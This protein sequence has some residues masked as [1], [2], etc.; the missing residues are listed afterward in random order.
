[1]TETN[2]GRASSALEFPVRIYYEDTDAGGIVYYANYLR[3][4]ERARTEWLRSRDIS[5][6]QLREAGQGLFVVRDLAIQYRQPAVLDD[7]LVVHTTI[8]IVR[9]ASLIFHQE[10]RRADE[11]LCDAVVTV[12]YVDG[13]T[14]RP[15]PLSESLQSIFKQARN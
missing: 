2:P 10:V 12:C 3:F 5:Q 13:M 14:R 6:Q 4:M 15:L 9:K 11:L 8:Q 7:L 1:M